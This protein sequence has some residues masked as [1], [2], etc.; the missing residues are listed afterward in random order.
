MGKYNT[1][2]WESRFNEIK[3]TLKKASK[4]AQ[5]ISQVD[6]RFRALTVRQQTNLS[7][8]LHLNLPNST[9]GQRDL[10][11]AAL[12]LEAL[13]R[14]QLL[15]SLMAVYQNMSALALAGR[16]DSL[17]FALEPQ[18]KKID[19]G[20]YR[21]LMAG[22]SIC[23]Y[24]HPGPGSIAC[25]VYCGQTGKPM[26]LSNEHVLRAQT[27]DED[28]APEI[29]QPAIHNGGIITD[30][31]AKFS[32]GYLNSEGDAA[33][34]YLS[35][36]VKF[37]NMTPEGR[38]FVGFGAEPTVGEMV[39]KRGAMS[40]LTIGRVKAVVGGGNVPHKGRGEIAFANQYVIEPWNPEDEFQIPGDSGSAL[41]NRHGQVLGVMHAGGGKSA[42]ATPI[43]AVMQK[44][45]LLWP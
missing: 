20:R 26:L 33:V 44:L 38:Q 17:L 42:M 1:K 27:T 19:F 12:F 16:I 34:A 36:G 22:V 31:V 11:R 23:G 35:E 18:G 8:S 4:R 24:P 6:A 10:L 25:F 29:L 2:S 3:E 30:E 37:A 40:N 41:F 45:N 43:V 39:Y 9:K 32:R 21:P 7:E 5:A 28:F 13:P 15:P 14:G